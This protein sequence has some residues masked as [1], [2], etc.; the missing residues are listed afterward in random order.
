[1]FVNDHAS[2]RGPRRRSFVIGLGAA[3]AITGCASAPTMPALREKLRVKV[4]PGA[5]NLPLFAAFEQGIFARHGLDVDLQFTQ[6]SGELRG[7]LAQGAF[8]I[9]HAAADNAVAL[10]ETGA[11]VAIVSGGDNSMNELFVQSDIASVA[12]LRGKTLIVDAPNTAYAL[13]AKKILKN[14]GVQPGEYSVK[15]VGGTFQRVGA[16]LADRTNSASTLNPPY[17]IQAA[18]R[19]LRSLGR[20]SELLGPYQGSSVFVMRPWA[21]AHPQPLQRYLAAFIE[22][23][24]WALAPANRESAIALLTKRLEVD[25]PLAASTYAALT[26]PRNGLAP[27]CVFDPQGFAAVLAIRAEIEG[28]WG[29]KPP[30]QERFVDLQWYRRALEI[31]AAPKS[32]RSS[33]RDTA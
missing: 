26:D 16:M 17:S 33:R 2:R 29:G 27:D 8:D 24:R 10:H 12:Q 4:F 21:Q 31:Q 30:A 7:G 15:Q 28:Q 13:Q 14:A 6:N 11:E 1:V 3:A 5:Q 19:G 20:M 23:T 18:Q 22:S 25:A 32:L 9:A